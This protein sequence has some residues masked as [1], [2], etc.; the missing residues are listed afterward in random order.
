VAEIHYLLH[1]L[2]YWCI[3][4]S[5]CLLR[6]LAKVVTLA[7]VARVMETFRLYSR[8]F[9]CHLVAWYFR[10]SSYHALFCINISVLAALYV[11]YTHM[12]A[13]RR[14]VLVKGQTLKRD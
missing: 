8:A 2:S 3:F 9:V 10:L 14:R 1:T 11:M 7:V 5:I 6:L 4:G 12:M 13:Q